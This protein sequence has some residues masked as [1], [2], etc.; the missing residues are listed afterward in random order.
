M[1]S[2]TPCRSTHRS[3]PDWCMNQRPVTLP[4]EPEPAPGSTGGQAPRKLVIPAKPVPAKA[5]SGN[6]LQSECHWVCCKDV[7][8]GN[9]RNNPDY[10][11]NQRPVILPVEP[12]PAPG[13]TGGA[14]SAKTRHSRLRGNDGAEIAGTTKAVGT[15]AFP[16]RAR[17]HPPGSA[18]SMI[19][20]TPPVG[21][22]MIA[23]RPTVGMSIGPAITTPPAS[24]TLA[25]RTSTSSTVT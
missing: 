22:W 8:T 18:Y 12:E 24:A 20:M 23:M 9:S 4:V 1:I 15:P 14:G 11:I 25:A 17:R 19:P 3:P 13:S 5:G 6:P 21:S 2:A 16:A 7:N 10:C